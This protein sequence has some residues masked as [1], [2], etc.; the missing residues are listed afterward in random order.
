MMAFGFGGNKKFRGYWIGALAL[1]ILAGVVFHHSGRTY[2][3]IRI[4][5]YAAIIGMLVYRFRSRRQLMGRNGGAPPSMFGRPSGYGGWNQPPPAN[6][7]TT[8]NH[9][10]EARL[11]E[12]PAPT[13]DDG[14]SA[15]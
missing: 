6:N 11:V 12:K 15:S 3:T 4:L 14:R 2:E 5:Y 7:G 10:I 1:V 8:S 13:D 9:P